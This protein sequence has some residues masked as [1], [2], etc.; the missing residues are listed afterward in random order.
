MVIWALYVIAVSALVGA[1]AFC[2][3]RAARLRHAPTRWYWL[4]AI[5][6]SIFVPAVIASISVQPPS[7]IGNATSRILVLRDMTSIPV[8]PQQW[9]RASNAQISHWRSFDSLLKSAWLLSS[10]GMLLILLAHAVMLRARVRRWRHG[11]LLDRGVLLST[12]VGPAV[13]GFLHPRIVVPAWV[14]HAPP[15]TQA[16]IIA[17]EYGHLEAKDPQLF[18]AAL[19]LLVAIPWNLPLWW[20]LRRLRQ[21]IEVDCD[22]RVIRGGQDVV[23]YSESLLTVGER[24]SAYIGAV[25]AMSES[26]S[27]LEQRINIMLGKPARWWKISAAALVCLS[28]VFVGAA[29]QVSPPNA[30]ASAPTTPEIT[31]DAAT[32]QRYVGHYKVADADLIMSVTRTGTQLTTQLTGQGAVDVYP[33]TATHFFVKVV[34]ANLDFVAEGDGPASAMVLHQNGRNITWTRIDDAVAAQ[35]SAELAARIQSNTPQPGSEAAVRDW[36]DRLEKGQ[37]AD[38]SRMSPMLAAAAKQQESMMPS[39]AASLGAFQS[40]AFQGVGTQGADSYVGKFEKSSL[41]IHIQLDSKGTIAMLGA[42]PYP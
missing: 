23:A 6:A 19:F 7:I 30:Q 21:A 34:D 10:S 35:A 3:E 28:M 33:Q 5:L 4:M 8:S 25:A 40:L 32:L 39:L 26:P 20:H 37:P 36:I 2:A 11:S 24:Q 22:A 41:L 14:E 17:H 18:T 16:A 9:I 29:A 38:Y 15:Q 42:Q 12:D 31:L 1:A 13:V 27:Q